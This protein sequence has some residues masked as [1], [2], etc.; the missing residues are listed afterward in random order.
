MKGGLHGFQG[1]RGGKQSLLKEYKEGG[2]T[3]QQYI[4]C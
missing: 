1:N 2:A 4:D 3:E